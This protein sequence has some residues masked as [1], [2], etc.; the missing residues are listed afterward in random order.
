MGLGNR[1]IHFNSLD[2]GGKMSVAKGVSRIG[3]V[4]GIIAG[5]SL[6]AII[7]ILA[8]DYIWNIYSFAIGSG[9]LRDVYT[10]VRSTLILIG[11]GMFG[12]LA[13]YLLG[14]LPF[15]WIARTFNWVIEGFRE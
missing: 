7:G 11:S 2:L 14:Y 1:F 5:I 4:L 8:V 10:A 3:H 9:S 15:F 6:G 12:S 13:G